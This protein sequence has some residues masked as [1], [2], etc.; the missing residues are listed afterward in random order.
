[1]DEAVLI[2]A[3]VDARMV[4]VDVSSKKEIY[5]VKKMFFYDIRCILTKKEVALATSLCYYLSHEDKCKP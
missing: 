3:A 5:L 1:M 2:T 4:E